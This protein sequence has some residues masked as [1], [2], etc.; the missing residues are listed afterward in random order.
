MVVPT[1]L[2]DAC[3]QCYVGADR[4]RL[5]GAAV[6]CVQQGWLCSE[7]IVLEFLQ[8]VLKRRFT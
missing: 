2:A 1:R 7:Q 8:L 4:S 6:P 5:R 3:Q